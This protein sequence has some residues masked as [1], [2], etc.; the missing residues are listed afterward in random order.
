MASDTKNLPRRA[1]SPSRKSE[2]GSSLLEAAFV[3]PLFFMLIFGILE[4]G[5]LFRNYLTV[6]NTTREGSR[7]ASV[8]GS[9]PEADFLTLRSIE[10]A[11]QAWGTENLDFVVIYHADGPD[12]TVPDSCKLGPVSGNAYP[13]LCNYYRPSEFSLSLVDA[14]GDP[15]NYFR[16]GTS[17]VDRHWCPSDRLTGLSEDSDDPSFDDGPAYIGVYVQAQHH[18]LTGFFGQTSTLSDDRII[19]IEPDK[20]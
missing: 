19:R 16:C 13:G 10:H 12:D 1:G 7:T 9:A 17:A 14:N 20:P 2:R 11:F 18:Y 6:T 15:T 3:T 5:F 8:S 4:F